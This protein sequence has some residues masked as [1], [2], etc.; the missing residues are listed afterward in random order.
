M[1]QQKQKPNFEF[2]LV[3]Q[4]CLTSIT[5][6]SDL[7]VSEKDT[8]GRYST[9]VQKNVGVALVSQKVFLNSIIGGL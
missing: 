7:Q 1:F 4:I 2:K 3:Y 6:P 8:D 9:T 5:R